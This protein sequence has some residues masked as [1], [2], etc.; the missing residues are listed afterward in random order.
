VIITSTP[1]LPNGVFLYQKSPFCLY[2]VMVKIMA[3][4]NLP[5][6][7]FYVHFPIWYIF[8]HFGILYKEK[9]GNLASDRKTFFCYI[10]KFLVRSWA[11]HRSKS[12]ALPWALATFKV[13][14]RAFSSCYQAGL[15]DFSWHNIPKRG[16]IY[17]ITTPLP[18]GH[19]IY[20][21]TLKYSKWP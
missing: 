2:Y 17:Q 19:I 8:P 5:F 4:L 11:Y 14:K 13:I 1:E 20:L 21:M 7:I 18:N 6:V 16:K 12:N 9:S 10:I 15:P 3:I